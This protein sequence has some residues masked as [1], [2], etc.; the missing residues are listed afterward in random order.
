MSN[1]D[2][3]VGEIKN[4]F[5]DFEVSTNKRGVVWVRVP[6]EKLKDVLKYF[7]D[8][9]FNHLT[10]ITALDHLEAKKFEL[11]YHILGFETKYEK[12]ICVR[13]EIDRDNPEI[14]TVIDIYAHALLYEREV[15]D[16]MGIRFRGHSGLK[17]LLLPEDTPEGFHPLRK[18]YK[19][20]IGEKK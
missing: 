12:P 3:L 9:G 11:I 18:D 20:E 17:R 7:Y 19:L 4:S 1:M 13:T 14:D 5:P 16:L 8:K 15:Y 6:H 10:T 2:E